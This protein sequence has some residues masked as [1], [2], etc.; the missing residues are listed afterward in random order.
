M[1]IVVDS[2]LSGHSLPLVVIRCHPLSL[3][4][5]PVFTRCSTLSHSF[6]SLSQSL[7]LFVT[8]C[9]TRLSFYKRSIFIV[10]F[11]LLFQI[12]GNMCIAIVCF[13]GCDVINFE[14]N[15]SNQGV[16][17]HDQKG[18]TKIQIFWER[19]ELL[20]WNKKKFSLFLKG[21][22]LSKI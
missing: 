5:A 22:H 6:H 14:I 16:F 9:T 17:E 2:S 19:R 7:S 4:A 8:R 1:L 20:R 10:W 15:L 18:K 21:F 13:R 12:L 3:V 11:P